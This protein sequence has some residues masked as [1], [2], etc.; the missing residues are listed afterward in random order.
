VVVL[1]EDW[2]D[3]VDAICDGSVRPVG[4]SSWFSP[5]ADDGDLFWV[6]SAM[7]WLASVLRT[8]VWS[9]DWSSFWA[10]EEFVE[11]CSAPFSAGVADLSEAVALSCLLDSAAAKS[12]FVVGFA[13]IELCASS[14]A[15]VFVSSWATELFDVWSEAPADLSEALAAIELL[16]LPLSLLAEAVWL[17]FDSAP[18]VATESLSLVEDFMSD[19]SVDA[20]EAVEL[21]DWSLLVLSLATLVLLALVESALETSGRAATDVFAPA[22]ISAAAASRGDF[23]SRAS[24]RLSARES[25]DSVLCAAM[26]ALVSVSVVAAVVVDCVAEP[27]AE[28]LGVALAFIRPVGVSCSSALV[29]LEV[30]VLDALGLVVASVVCAF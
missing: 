22:E 10:S 25:F 8:L 12:L 17:S 26:L 5:V 24:V 23:E 13:P 16:W 28:T 21:F 11:L 15:A 30:V 9:F 2:S 19:L 18:V 20:T 3:E 1:F 7:S 27:D 29:V 14:G 4:E 6:P